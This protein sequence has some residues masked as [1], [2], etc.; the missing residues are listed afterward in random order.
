MAK[1]KNFMH[2]IGFSGFGDHTHGGLT[3]FLSLVFGVLT[4]VF[5]GGVVEELTVGLP[6]FRDF[7]SGIAKML[8][9]LGI[10][11]VFSFLI[12]LWKHIPLI[13][14]FSLFSA[15]GLFN[16]IHTGA[17]EKGK[18]Y[19]AVVRSW[20]LP[21]EEKL[22]EMEELRRVRFAIIKE[23][24]NYSDIGKSFVPKGALVE[25]ITRPGEESGVYIVPYKGIEY[26]MGNDRFTRLRT[27][28]TAVLR[29]ECALL[30]WGAQD[31]D[32]V[33]DIPG[34]QRVLLTG[35]STDDTLT[36]EVTHEGDTGWL[37]LENLKL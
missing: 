36:V 32:V 24:L 20:F 30:A 17:I 15:I 13:I 26:R 10:L 29:H 23:D 25:V 35:N 4:Y 31:A 28:R 22:Q 27:D 33:K 34:G 19:P 5:M 9:L 21:P 7:F 37:R 8:I 11:I 1:S 18:Y 12:V 16:L 6:A 14:L 2:K 3:F